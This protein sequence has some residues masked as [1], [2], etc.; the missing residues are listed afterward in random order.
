MLADT[1]NTN[2]GGK[3]TDAVKSL[4][5]TSVLQGH[6]SQS[7]TQNF[8]IERT[9][10]R[11]NKRLNISMMEHICKDQFGNLYVVFISQLPDG[12]V[13][14]VADWV[15]VEKWNEAGAKETVIV[16]E[17]KKFKTFNDDLLAYLQDKAFHAFSLEVLA[18]LKGQNAATIA[19]MK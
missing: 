1:Q 11:H 3:L 17:Y 13:W 14:A 15:A 4:D 7:I 12:D 5:P 19:S 16:R 6:V 2:I 8:N 9:R 10:L 18:W